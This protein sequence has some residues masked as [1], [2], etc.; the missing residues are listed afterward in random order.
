[1]NLVVH[2]KKP[3]YGTKVYINKSV[4]DKAIKNRMMLEIVIPQG[5]GIVDPKEW[6]ARGDIMKKVFK[7]PDRPMILYGGNVPLPETKGE[8]ETPIKKLIDESQE[9]LFV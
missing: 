7:Y 8:V 6:K 2:I 9:K 1:M 5:R 4:V 3:V